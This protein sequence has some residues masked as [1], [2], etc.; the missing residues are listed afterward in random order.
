VLESF[1]PRVRVLTEHI[2]V[3]D[4]DYQP[5]LVRLDVNPVE[6][7][8]QAADGGPGA[9]HIT[10]P[11]HGNRPSNVNFHVHGSTVGDRVVVRVKTKREF[12]LDPG[13]LLELPLLGQADP[14][15][16]D[17][18]LRIEFAVRPDLRVILNDIGILASFD[19][20]QGLA[21]QGIAAQRR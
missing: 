18:F 3:F 4:V 12:S 1:F 8:L 16:N 9:V 11:D 20:E 14:V 13:K 21:A 15:R 17:R 5:V 2:D 19:F 10:I 6:K 7:G